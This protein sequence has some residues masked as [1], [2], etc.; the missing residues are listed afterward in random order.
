MQ[1]LQRLLKE[2]VEELLA[3]RD[4]TLEVSVMSRLL[5]KPVVAAHPVCIATASF[6]RNKVECSH[7]DGQLHTHS[8]AWARSQP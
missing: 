4:A 6:H 2:L 5:S 8:Q 3:V 7:S 1:E